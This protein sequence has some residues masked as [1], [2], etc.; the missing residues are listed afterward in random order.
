[1]TNEIVSYKWQAVATDA[2][3]PSARWTAMEVMALLSLYYQPDI[4]EGVDEMAM[5]NWIEALADL[6]QDAVK[7]GMKAWIRG[8]TRRP[9]PAD[10]RRLAESHLE[11]KK[12]PAP[13]DDEWPFRPQ[14]VDIKSR[15][16]YSARMAEAFPMIKRI[17]RAE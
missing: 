5:A 6:P 8:E 12:P 15:Q 2:P 4:P 11:P 13:E 9:T 16:E 3:R 1:M 7:L 10:I 14:V 17:P